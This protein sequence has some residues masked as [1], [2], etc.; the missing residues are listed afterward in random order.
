MPAGK[1]ADV[2]IVRL[3]PEHAAAA[4]R[5]HIAGQPGTFLTSRRGRAYPIYA[6][7]RSRAAASASPR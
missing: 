7:F 5:L 3:A 2:R 4:A 1:P 6:C